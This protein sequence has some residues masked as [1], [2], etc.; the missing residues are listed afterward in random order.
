MLSRR[1][2]NLATML[3][4]PLY[5]FRITSVLSNNVEKTLSFFNWLVPITLSERLKITFDFTFL[6]RY[7][8]AYF[9]IITQPSYQ[10]TFMQCCFNDDPA[11]QA[12]FQHLSNLFSASAKQ[13]IFIPANNMHKTQALFSFNLFC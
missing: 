4:Q 3:L 11:L 9:P 12:V 6:P 8:I 5:N 13:S 2:Y 7:N 1:F 10:E